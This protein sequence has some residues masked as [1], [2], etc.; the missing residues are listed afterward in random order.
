M[1]INRATAKMNAAAASAKERLEKYGFDIRI[2]TDYMN[3]FFKTVEKTEKAKFVT[4]AVVIG[5]EGIAQED[6]YC[7][8]VGAAVKRSKVDD[9]MLGED[10]AA[11]NKMIDETIEVLDGYEDKLEG[12]RALA[13][14]ANE[15]YEKMVADVNAKQKKYR[16]ISIIGNAAFFVGVA[17]LVLVAIWRHKNGA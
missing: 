11:F 10:I 1:L 2:E 6:E 16:R 17:I 9:T 3:R 7:L 5:G 8:S 15:E 14:K 4:T 12:L 13:A